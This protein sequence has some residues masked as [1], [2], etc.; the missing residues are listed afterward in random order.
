MCE[1]LA[2]MVNKCTTLDSHRSA[3]F[4]DTTGEQILAL[5]QEYQRRQGREKVD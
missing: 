4:T 5:A 3:S 1:E 2:E